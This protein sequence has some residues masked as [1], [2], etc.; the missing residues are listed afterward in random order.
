M[1]RVLAGAAGVVLGYV[2]GG[3]GGGMLVSVLSSNV[4]DRDVEAAMTGAF[5]LGPIG[6]VVGLAVA[7]R[8][9]RR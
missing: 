8:L 6:A 4:H 5:V 1:R 3:F 7:L 2:V 9:A